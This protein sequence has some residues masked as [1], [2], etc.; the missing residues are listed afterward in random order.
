MTD[1]TAFLVEDKLNQVRDALHKEAYKLACSF[2][3]KDHK[4]F[5]EFHKDTYDKL[6]IKAKQVLDKG[7]S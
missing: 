2:L 3:S 5:K 4:D 7:Q 6:L 1:L